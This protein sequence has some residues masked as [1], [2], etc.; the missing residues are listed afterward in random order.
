MQNK[1]IR[2]VRASSTRETSPAG[3][4]CLFLYCQPSVFLNATRGGPR[5]EPTPPLPPGRPTGRELSGGPR[6]RCVLRHTIPLTAAGLNFLPCRAERGWK[7][8]G[9]SVFARHVGPA[10]GTSFSAAEKPRWLRAPL[11]A[12]REGDAF[13]TP[14][15]APLPFRGRPFWNSANARRGGSE[16][17]HRWHRCLGPLARS[18]AERPLPGGAA[19]AR[20]RLA[21]YAREP[22]AA[23]ACAQEMSGSR[24][25]LRAG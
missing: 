12:R 15:L 22:R 1:A 25:L 7:P 2:Q 21:D 16:P 4:R 5:A 17:P 8:R 23:S 6:L 19:A 20:S 11:K 10:P 3:T 13:S 14:G 24:R 9:C 18:R